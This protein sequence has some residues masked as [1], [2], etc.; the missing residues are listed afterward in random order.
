MTNRKSYKRETALGMIVFWLSS[1]VWGVWEPAAANMAESVG[2]YIIPFA[3]MAFGLEGY[4]QV[5]ETRNAFR[6]DE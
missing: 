4:R 3:T 1:S 5:E 2:L 6:P